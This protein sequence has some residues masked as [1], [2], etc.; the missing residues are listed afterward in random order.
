MAIVW[1]RLR[2]EARQRWG[3]W[4]ALVL[5]VAVG[6]GIVLGALAGARRT[7][8]AHDRFLVSVNA[9]DVAVV[10][11]GV[12]LDL[13][14]V[15]RLPQVAD[16]AGLRYAL[17][18][19]EP[20]PDGRQI[21]LD[22]LIPDG[23][24]AYERLNRPK[25]LA[26]RHPET[27]R[28][29][30]AAIA[31]AASERYGL[32][33]G[34]SVTVTF[35][36]P[37][38]LGPVL[39]GEQLPPG[40]LRTT[41]RIVGVVATPTELLP[42]SS[43]PDA[44]HLTPAFARQ[45]GEEIGSLPA[46]MYKLRRGEAGAN[47]F[48]LEVERLA[49]GQPVQFITASLDAADVERS[50]HLQAVALRVFAALTAL[51]GLLILGQALVRQVAL[52]AR[53]HPA[54]TAMGMTRPQLWVTALAR[55]A[56]VTA[57]GAALAVAVAFLLSPLSPTGLARD[58]EPSPGFAFDGATFLPG[59]LAMVVVALV[60]SA[61]P[62]WTAVRRHSAEPGAA[63]A[64]GA[65][66]AG[67][68]SR[69]RLVDR[70]GGVGLPVPALTGVRMA[71]EP[72]VESG[73]RLTRGAVIST[74]FC[75]SAVAVAAT[76]A[77]SLQ[78]L[79]RT[80]PLYG[81]NWD[82]LIGNPFLDDRY[83]ETV[84]ALRASRAVSGFSSV[85][86]S[87]LEIGEGRAMAVGF[88]TVQGSILPPVVEGRAPRQPDEVL[89]G[90]RTLR[91]IG[92]GIGDVVRVRVGDRAERARV[93]GRGVLPGLVDSLDVSGLGEGVLFTDQGLRRLV[94]DAP[95]NLFAVQLAE[96]MDASTAIEQLR[97]EFPDQ[98]TLPE[99][100]Q[101][102]ADFG[103]V[104]SLPAALVAL[105]AVLSVATLAHTFG[106][107]VRRRR[108]DLAILKTLGFV[109]SQLRIAVAAQATTVMVLALAIGIPLGLVAGR[110]TWQ[111]FADSLGIVPEP[112]VP[113]VAALAI[114]PLALL[115]ANVVAAVPGRWAARVQ[116]TAA[117]QAE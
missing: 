58:V 81:W 79:L 38:E 22:I 72:G 21:N 10:P 87:D 13:E 29:D 49:G 101:T 23:D 7:D 108:R 100:P 112:V 2:S 32:G 25:V 74:V 52:A 48:K 75:I 40:G 111:L 60:I 106:M 56:V 18:A 91:D 67:A 89:V 90:T 34:D 9:F 66:G 14:A 62:T 70:L 78:H 83:D 104:D 94:P 97:Q 113:V 57:V 1:F 39:S 115:I 41:F 35:L 27:S 63:G 88:D 17:T 16:A 36:T 103:T 109:R 64:A 98:V 19:V 45:H 53:D 107:A 82:V 110:W 95:R 84:P 86:F 55:A 15:R 51:C 85:I 42:T 46:T 93:V 76:F 96:G 92:A 4:L 5:L 117:L 33:L 44:F 31:S 8:S 105:L 43:N 30:E 73:W 47:Q 59:A 12:P 11:I 24:G 102:V 77:A 50:I 6:G 80:P 37:E 54:L 3:A 114:V 20:A 69:T 61:A 116:P 26:G 99:P 65:A 28:A 68:P 71:L